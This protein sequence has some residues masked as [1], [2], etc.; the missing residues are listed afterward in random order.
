MSVLSTTTWSKAD[1]S[2]LKSTVDGF[3]AS[4]TSG[5]DIAKDTA[6]VAGFSS[7][8]QALS[9][10]LWSENHIL[11]KDS[12][13]QFQKAVDDFASSYTGGQNLTQDTAAWSSLQSG[14]RSFA[15]AAF[16]PQGATNLAPKNAGPGLILGLVTLSVDSPLIFE[17]ES[18]VPS[19][20]SALS[21]DNLSTLQLSVDTFADTYTSGA[22]A[23]KDKAALDSLQS[24][25]SKL[26]QS[27]WAS[28]MP[29]PPVTVMPLT[30]AQVS[31]Q[32][33][34]SQGVSATGVAVATSTVASGTA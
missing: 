7:G 28:S 1:I 31:V 25:L 29:A 34:P 24:S 3:A 20:S 26:A 12:L 19:A 27:A 30:T 22:D 15:Q 21:K 17:L 2:L 23:A 10:Q 5:A 6:A 9:I 13:A 33:A 32:A 4:Y 14:L 18:L 11:S 16:D 8:L